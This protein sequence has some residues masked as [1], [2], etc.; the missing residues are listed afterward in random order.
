M[1]L[2]E[3]ND[4]MNTGSRYQVSPGA[5]SRWVVTMKFT[6]VAML[7]NPDRKMPTTASTT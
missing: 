1:M 4:Q 5:R 6:P 7:L 2:V 3:Y